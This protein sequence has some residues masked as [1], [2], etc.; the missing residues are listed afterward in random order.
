MLGYTNFK[1]SDSSGP[2]VYF[3]FGSRDLRVCN[4]AIS[5]T[6]CQYISAERK[7]FSEFLKNNR[8]KLV[9]ATCKQY[10]SQNAAVSAIRGEDFQYRCD[11]VTSFPAA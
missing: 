5:P 9:L 3:L 6:R 10:C 2:P 7:R 1:G 8:L 4:A 11:V